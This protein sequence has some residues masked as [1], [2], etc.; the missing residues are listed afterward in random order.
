MPAQWSPAKAAN[1]RL[2]LWEEKQVSTGRREK[3][4]MFRNDGVMLFRIF[5]GIQ[6]TGFMA[7]IGTSAQ[8]KSSK[9]NGVVQITGYITQD[10]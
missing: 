7:I 8:N 2:S 5:I 6:T 4:I 3:K 1:P 9:P 10:L